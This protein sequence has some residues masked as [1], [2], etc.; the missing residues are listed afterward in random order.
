MARSPRKFMKIT[1]WPSRIGPTGS[2]PRTTTNGGR[3][4]ST[5]S[6]FS[7]R[8]ALTAAGAASTAFSHRPSTCTSQPRR[9]LSQLRSRSMVITSRPPPLAMA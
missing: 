5:S 2:P 4:W 8:A 3:S 7:S 6:G 9:T 1:A